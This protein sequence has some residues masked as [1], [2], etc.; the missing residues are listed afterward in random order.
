MM[1]HLHYIYLLRDLVLPVCILHLFSTGQY[2]SP[3]WVLILLRIY[4]ISSIPLEDLPVLII[5]I[6]SPA[7]HST[8]S[9]NS[10]TP[11]ILHPIIYHLLQFADTTL[12]DYFDHIA[13]SVLY[14]FYLLLFIPYI[15]MHTY[16]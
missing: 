2:H 11:F 10:N 15:A 5:D 13:C 9:D 1:E 8:L 12:A 14:N 4:P 7:P 6:F 3:F 16:A